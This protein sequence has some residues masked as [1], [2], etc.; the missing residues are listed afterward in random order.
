MSQIIFIFTAKEM[1]S[2]FGMGLHLSGL[3]MIAVT[4][5]QFLQAA[6]LSGATETR[7]DVNVDMYPIERAEYKRAV[8]SIHIRLGEQAFAAALAAGRSM[9]IDQFLAAQELV[10]KLEPILTVSSMPTIV[11][12]LPTD[13][14]S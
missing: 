14:H 5:G 3:A 1:R 11:K 2:E 7:L 4:E 12:P 9:T 6:H 10:N 13:I 8:E